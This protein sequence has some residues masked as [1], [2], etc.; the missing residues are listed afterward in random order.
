MVALHTNLKCLVIIY[1]D[2][3]TRVHEAQP[4]STSD[5]ACQQ[6]TIRATYCLG[7]VY[8]R[9]F[10]YGMVRAGGLQSFVVLDFVH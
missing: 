2:R 9:C 7:F 10:V 5:A 3:N 8:C 6:V 4:A 1:N